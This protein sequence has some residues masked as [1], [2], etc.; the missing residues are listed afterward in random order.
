M[1]T[2]LLCVHSNQRQI[3]TDIVWGFHKS[4][5]DFDVDFPDGDFDADHLFL[6]ELFVDVRLTLISDVDCLT[7]TIWIGGVDY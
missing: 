7:L 5:F 3:L 4:C 6:T 1:Q 2:L